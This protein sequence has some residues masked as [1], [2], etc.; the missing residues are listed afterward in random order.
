MK[1]LKWLAKD[2]LQ[3]Q[4]LYVKNDLTWRWSNKAYWGGP[5]TSDWFDQNKS[6]YIFINFKAYVNEVNK[7]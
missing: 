3:G 2:S 5:M 7:G 1:I 4:I 6:N